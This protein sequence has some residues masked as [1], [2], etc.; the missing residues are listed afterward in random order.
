VKYVNETSFTAGMVAFV[1]GSG[2]KGEVDAQAS[3]FQGCGRASLSRFS[4]CRRYD[5][6]SGVADT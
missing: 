2:D 1:D 6:Q 5:R 3:T 4:G